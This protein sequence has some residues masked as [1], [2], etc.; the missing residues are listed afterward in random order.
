MMR[1]PT[2]KSTL[3]RRDTNRALLVDKL[4][5][6]WLAERSGIALYDRVIERLVG[7]EELESE[8]TRFRDQEQL[9]LE[10]LEQLLAE[11]GR[12]P[13]DAPSTPGVNLAASEISAM[14]ELVRDPQLTPRHLVEVLLSFELLDD[15][16][17]DI[18]LELAKQADLDDEW[19]RSFRVAKREEEE[20]VH[21]LKTQL[22]RIERMQLFSAE[23]MGTSI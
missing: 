21:V 20:H 19:L 5:E 7:I 2:R 10:M 14:L 15:G 9:H 1:S 13:R 11:L 18:L 4:S 8:L 17:W 6:R 12:R 16:G 22:V 23:L 3:V